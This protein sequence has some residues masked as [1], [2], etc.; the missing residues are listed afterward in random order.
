MQGL[1][2]VMERNL[3]IIGLTN[4][5]KAN[6]YLQNIQSTPVLLFQTHSTVLEGTGKQ[7]K[8]TQSAKFPLLTLAYIWLFSYK[9][10]N[11]RLINLLSVTIQCY[12]HLET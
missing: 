12:V 2:G 8:R 1:R 3:W 11:P 9:G 7:A 10:L 6:T 5:L 4:L